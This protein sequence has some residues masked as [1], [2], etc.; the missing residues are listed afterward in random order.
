[1]K[2]E[3]LKLRREGKSYRQIVEELG[4]SKSTVSYYLAE[5]GRK[6]NVQ[7]NKDRRYKLKDKAVQY[8]GGKCSSCGYN[9]YIG[10]LEFHHRVPDNKDFEISNRN[11]SKKWEVVKKELDKCD[12]LCANCHREV[13]SNISCGIQAV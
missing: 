10:A 11:I 8:K 2:K 13:H 3:I 9:K 7:R 6:R 4:C 12:L 5:E 1:M